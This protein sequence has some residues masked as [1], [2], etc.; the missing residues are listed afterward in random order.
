M[1]CRVTELRGK[2]VVLRPL[3]AADTAGLRAMHC[4][5]EVARWWGA[6]D[7]RFP[8][9]DDPESTRFAILEDGELAG[10]AQY[11]EEQ[12]PDYRYAWID[13]FLAP[14]HQ[15]RGLGVDTVRTL[16]DHLVH[17][18]GHHR[19]TID[20]AAENVAAVRAYAK[21]GFEAIGTMRRAWR[22]PEGHWRD[23]LLMERVEPADHGD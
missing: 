15:G 9:H 7:D 1:L 20:P 21:A 5:P 13:L 8:E 19:V 11:G 12:E 4:A 23:V 2:C 6:M 17:D 3:A 10:M 18:R 16:A 22:D 14:E